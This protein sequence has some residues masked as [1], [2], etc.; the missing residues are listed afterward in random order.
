M[1]PAP[2]KV[3]DNA[4][5]GV[6][7]TNT[8]GD[9][10]MFDRATFPPGVAPVAGHVDTHGTLRQAAE[11]EVHEEVGL[12]VVSLLEVTSGWRNN[13]CRRLPGPRGVGHQWTVFRAVVTGT[14]NPSARETRNARWVSRPDVLALCSRTSRYAAGDLT[15]AEF[16]EKP[17]IEPVWV[18]WLLAGSTW[19]TDHDLGLIDQLAANATPKESS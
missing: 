19:L 13:R 15:D 2:P 5:V 18:R 9:H 3:C 4:V 8:V 14:L 12:T 7:I 6:I 16:A 17:G 10:L 11:A 1:T